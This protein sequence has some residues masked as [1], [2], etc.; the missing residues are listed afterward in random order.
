MGTDMTHREIA[1]KVTAWVDEVIAPLVVALNEVPGVV[2]LDSCQEDPD[3]L[4]RV[5]FCTHDDAAIQKTLDFLWVGVSAREWCDE[6]Q[7]SLWGGCD[8][9]A[10]VA[11]L[12]CP[13]GLVQALGDT[14]RS[15]GARMTPFSG[16]SGCRA[17]G[18]WTV[19]RCHP[20]TPPSDGDIRHPDRGAAPG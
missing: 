19:H 14:I 20:P 12:A 5:T 2:T 3:G 16:D 17:P 4:A 9:T 10:H 1:V 8:D 13:P 11:D 7:L 18:S 6:I 15:T